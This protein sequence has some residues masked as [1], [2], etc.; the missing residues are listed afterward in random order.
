MKVLIVD[1][2]ELMQELLADVFNE[3]GCQTLCASNG[4]EALEHYQKFKPDIIILDVMMPVMDGFEVCSQIRNTIGDQATKIFLLTGM[5]G[6][7]IETKGISL[8]AN[9]VL[10]KPISGDILINHV[11]GDKQ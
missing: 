6:E 10:F 5:G 1:D 7:Q 9:Q 2:E 4:K 3:E 11:I 8:G